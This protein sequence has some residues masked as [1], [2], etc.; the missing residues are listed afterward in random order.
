MIRL[1]PRSTRTD[2][3]FPYAALFRSVDQMHHRFIKVHDMDKSKVVASIVEHGA[4]T[5]IFSNTKRAADRLAR[6]LDDLGVK[7]EPIHGDL[8]Q[9][10]RAKA[11]Q[12]FTEG[13]RQPRV[14]SAVAAR[15]LATDLL[16][17]V[18]HWDTPP[19][20]NTHHP[21]TRPPPP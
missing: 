19:D 5:L 3:L 16:D 6:D 18:I 17:T 11:L 10:A 20:P 4:R 21:R 14:A 9:R 1:H 15:G 2:T 8:P 13:K 7:A 12:R